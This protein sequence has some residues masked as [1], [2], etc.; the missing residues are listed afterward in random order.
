MN[1][2]DREAYLTA[3]VLA[4]GTFAR[5]RFFDLHAHP[6]MR[7]LRR[8]ATLL[9]GIIRHLGRQ[10]A[11]EAGEMKSLDPD[12]DGR[13]RLVYEV[14]SVGLRRTATLDPIELALV[15]FALARMPGKDAPLAHDD[16]DRIRIE[17]ALARLTTRLDL[18]PAPPSL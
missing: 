4:P 17:T 1:A 10:S 16:P 15:R 3:M 9:R 8:R 5:N 6:E 12:A 11:L 2:G 7:K 18:P 14:P 13:T